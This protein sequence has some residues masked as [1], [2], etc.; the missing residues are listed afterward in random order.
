MPTQAQ[1]IA[2]LKEQVAE[3]QLMLGTKFLGMSSAQ[4]ASELKPENEL[5][6]G[7]YPY[8]LSDFQ[9]HTAID[10]MQGAPSVP[11]P[12]DNQIPLPR[13]VLPLVPAD[14][15]KV[16]TVDMRPTNSVLLDDAKIASMESQG[17]QVF[18]NP[19]QF[20]GPVGMG[21]PP[22]AGHPLTMRKSGEVIFLSKVLS[23]NTQNKTG[24]V[25]RAASVSGVNEY[26]DG[27][28]LIRG[29]FWHN[30]ILHRVQ[31]IID[32]FGFDSAGTVSKSHEDYS[33]PQVER[34][35]DWI[36]REDAEAREI[37]L[38]ACRAGWGARIA[39]SSDTTNMN[40]SENDGK[41]NFDRSAQ[42]IEPLPLA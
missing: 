34:C 5:P 35:Q 30:G 31:S 12:V 8:I 14:G 41:P 19:V 20:D 17:A 2:T 7:R 36:V 10:S 15:K 13:D 23:A 16:G 38:V 11:P 3:L 42:V 18:A 4:L 37:V 27:T 26:D 1:E 24:D 39:A 25:W 33:K 40:N 28:R 9:L 29:G 22:I 21:G 32:I 6:G